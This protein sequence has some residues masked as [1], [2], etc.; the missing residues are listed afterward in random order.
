MPPGDSAAKD[1]SSLP[2][3]RGL[4]AHHWFVLM[5][6]WL[7]WFFDTMDQQ[8]FILARGP[9]MTALLGQEV[10]KE[11]VRFYSGIATTLLM[12][13]WATGGAGP[14]PCS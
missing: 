5:V 12:L 7:G 10:T 6:C 2:W 4:T 14:R 3:Y 13:G 11:T 8:L 9:A 1:P